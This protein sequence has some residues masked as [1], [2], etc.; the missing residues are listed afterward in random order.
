[1]FVFVF[2]FPSGIYV[3][4]L[5]TNQKL[6]CK[7]FRVRNSQ[8]CC[9]LIMLQRYSCSAYQVFEWQVWKLQGDFLKLNHGL[10][11]RYKQKNSIYMCAAFVHVTYYQTWG[12]VHE[13]WYLS[14]FKYTSQS[15]CTLLKYF[16]ISAGVLVLIL[17][18]YVE[19]LYVLGYL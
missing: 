11:R 14:T 4:D 13:Y 18:Y 7:Y 9:S 19:Y 6:L 1:M 15:T 12:Q 8:L 10:Q 5:R 16:L 2:V 17:K 3:K